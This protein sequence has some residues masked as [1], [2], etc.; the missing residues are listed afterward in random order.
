MKPRLYAPLVALLGTL[1]LPALAAAEIT[2]E[3]PVSDLTLVM[4]EPVSI[5]LPHGV[6]D[7][8]KAGKWHHRIKNINVKGKR[9]RPPARRPHL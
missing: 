6:T 3:E 5:Q 2:L 1:I 9:R 4:H 8:T 7:S